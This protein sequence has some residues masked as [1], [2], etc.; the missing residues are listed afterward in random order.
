MTDIPED[1][2]ILICQYIKPIEY[3]SLRY[4]TNHY[5]WKKLFYIQNLIRACKSFAY[6]KNYSFLVHRDS[7][8]YGDNEFCS[9]NFLGIYNGPRYRTMYNEWVAYIDDKNNLYTVTKNHGYH[10]INTKRYNLFDIN[11]GA[12][13]DDIYKE[14]F[15][16]KEIIDYIK[17]SWLL[18]PN[19]III[20]KSFPPINMTQKELKGYLKKYKLI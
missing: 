8:E 2:I 12:M 18:P 14:K 1:I 17:S 11:F 16:D 15:H 20:R 9:V 5:Y 3:T 7:G 13:L 6:I 4:V 10:V 19:Y